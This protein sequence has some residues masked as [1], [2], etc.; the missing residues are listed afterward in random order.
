MPDVM[1]SVQRSNCMGRIRSRDTKPELRLRAALWQTGVRYRLKSKLKG[2]PDLVFARPRLAVFVDG[3]FWHGCPTHGTKPKS[4][5]TYWHA[6]L[7]KNRARDSAINLELEEAGWT[8]IRI[9]EHEIDADLERVVDM[10]I[11]Q[12][13]SSSSNRT[14]G[15]DVIPRQL[16]CDRI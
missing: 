1:T 6:K 15:P 7:E 12:I 5:E 4:N 9:W 13:H 16:R 10:I 8:V 14:D 3:C 2:K 11:A